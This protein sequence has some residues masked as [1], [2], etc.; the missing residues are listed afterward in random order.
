MWDCNNAQQQSDK[1]EEP[2]VADHA[3]EA[4]KVDDDAEQQKDKFHEQLYDDE[5]KLPETAAFEEIRGM[6]GTE[7]LCAAIEQACAELADIDKA[8]SKMVKSPM[9][10]ATNEALGK[11]SPYG[12]GNK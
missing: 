7:E 6:E 12:R 9:E 4:P 3:L 11:Q 10:G 2:K 1:W 5:L 8:S